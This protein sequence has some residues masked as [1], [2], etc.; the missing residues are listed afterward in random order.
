MQKKKT[1]KNIK[2][3]SSKI[4]VSDGIKVIKHF[5]NDIFQL[6]TLIL[7]SIVEEIRT[8]IL[9]KPLS[10]QSKLILIDIF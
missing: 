5:Q 9:N 1:K 4:N 7:S 10:L 6:N 3:L 2:S 8:L